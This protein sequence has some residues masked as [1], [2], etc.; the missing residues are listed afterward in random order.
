MNNTNNATSSKSTNNSY[1]PPSFQDYIPVIWRGKWIIVITILLAVNVAFFYTQSTEPVYQASVTVFVNTKGEQ[2][3]LY[4]GLALDES[5]NINNEM[6]LLGSQMMAE[7]VAGLL[8]ET[9]YIDEDSLMPIPILT[10]FDEEEDSIIWLSTSAVAA[11][12][13]NVVSLESKRDTDFITISARSRDNREAALL[14]NAYARVYH[15]RNFKI[16]RKQSTNVREFLEDQLSSKRSELERAEQQF[17]NYMEQH[18]VV[19]IDDETRRVIDQISQLEAQRE[20][21]EVEIQSLSSTHISLLRQLEEQEPNVARNISSADN[22]YIRMIQEQMAQ[23]EVERDLTL[24]QNPEARTDERYTRMLAEIEEQL[25]VLRENLRRRTDEFMQSIAPGMG[26]DP[27]GYIRLLRQRLLETDIEM[28]GLRYRKAAVEESLERFERLFNRLPRVTMEYARLQRARTSSEQLYLMVEQR[29]NEAIITE[30]SEFGSVE[31]ID[32]AQVPSSP[33]GPNL[34]LNLIVGL[35]L[36]AGLG[37]AFVIGR[38]Q[39]FGPLRVPEELQKNGFVTLSMV[40]SMNHEIKK[41]MKNGKFV[42]YGKELDPKLI[43]LNNPLSPSAESFR[44]LRTRLKHAQTDSKLRTLIV[45]G[46]NPGE[47]KSTIAVNMG[48]SY[49]QAGGKTLLI[50]CDLRKPAL[51]GMLG[52]LRK[53]GLVEVLAEEMSFYEAVQPT[54]IDN[55]D[56]L[57]GGTLPANPAEILG[58]DNMKSLLAMLSER[59]QLILIDSPPVLAA[60]DPLVLSTLTDGL[61][62]VAAAGRTKM[63]E[64]DLARESIMSVGAQVNGVVLNFFDY[65]QAY[66][67]KYA[68]KYYRYGSY[69][70]SRNGK[71][72]GALKEVKVE[73]ARDNRERKIDGEER[74]NVGE[75]ERWRGGEAEE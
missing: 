32:R 70:Y 18:G 45:T 50:D 71:G 41:S 73:S 13:R 53:P 2:A 42:K 61:I 75:E 11:R 25:G 51:A 60:S 31:I 16:S 34:R 65:R 6:Q 55:L 39:L 21:I 64:L 33:V 9:Q 72:S 29:Y 12:L 22:P 69:G 15:D 49:A 40:S 27:A 1:A 66:G 7:L 57:A 5:K 19:R 28:Q 20:A 59:Y 38:E 62:M 48:I 14:A 44:L 68:Y 37:V 63:K 26:D 74:R 4:G 47:G 17:R 36:G 8:M 23:L 58:S 10:Y 30:Q 24:T 3:S 67:S 54:V 43:M 35:F 56:F 52:Q 46:P